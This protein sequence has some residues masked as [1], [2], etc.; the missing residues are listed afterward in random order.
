MICSRGISGYTCKKAYKNGLGAANSN[1]RHR[2]KHKAPP[3][4]HG[5]NWSSRQPD[6]FPLPPWRLHLR[7]KFT[8]QSPRLASQ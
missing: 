2:K 6:H 3:E 1:F 4:S 5:K 8:R 7:F